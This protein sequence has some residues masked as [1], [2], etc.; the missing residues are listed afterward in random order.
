[1]SLYKDLKT[2]HVNIQLSVIFLF[3][4]EKYYLKTLHVNIQ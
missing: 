4:L 1:M 2:L 3:Y